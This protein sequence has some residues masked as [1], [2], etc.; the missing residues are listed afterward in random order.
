MPSVSVPLYSYVFCSNSHPGM[1]RGTH[2]GYHS[3]SCSMRL[4]YGTETMVKHASSCIVLLTQL[5]FRV[6]LDTCK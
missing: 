4:P 1:C 6:P 5:N 2:D 3:G